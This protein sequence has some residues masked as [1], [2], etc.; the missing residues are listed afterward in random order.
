MKSK[1][2]NEAIKNYYHEFNATLFSLD[3]GLLKDDKALAG[4]LWR[5]IFG[6]DS[7][8]DPQIIELLLRYVLCQMENLYINHNSQQILFTGKIQWETFEP[9][10]PI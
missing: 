9:F 1:V 7:K 8:M 6:M 4:A 10:I 5:N 2:K 3:E